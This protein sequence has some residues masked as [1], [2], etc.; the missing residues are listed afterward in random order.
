MARAI[1]DD[2]GQRQESFIRNF[3]SSGLQAQLKSE[4]ATEEQRSPQDTF[5]C[6]LAKMISA[7]HTQPPRRLS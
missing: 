1:R 5:G 2:I 3:Q 7:M 6:Q 4:D